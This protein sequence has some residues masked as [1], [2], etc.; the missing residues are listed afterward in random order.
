MKRLVE[1]DRWADLWYM[2]LHPY[3]KL[4]LSYLYD[5]CDSA[6]F[7]DFN[8]NLWLTQIQGKTSKDKRY[9]IFSKEDL[10][11]SIKDLEQKLVSDKKKKLFIIDFLKHQKKLPLIKGMEES[12]F[13]IDKLQ[14]NLKKFNNAPEIANLLESVKPPEPVVVENTRSKPKK[15]TPPEYEE[16][17]EHYLTEKPDADIGDVKNLYDHYVSCGWKVGNN[18]PMHDWQASIRTS[19]RRNEK[20]PQKNT[21]GG[22]KNEKESKTKIAFSVADDLKKQTENNG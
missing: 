16:W 15:F 2:E 8:V 1:T 4:L 20:F 10:L 5:N 18:K 13:I 9:S 7:I 12:D 17:Y 14:S 22:Y 6:G 19:I 21:G 11:N 3:P